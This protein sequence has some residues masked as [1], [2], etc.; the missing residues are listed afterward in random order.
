VETHVGSKPGRCGEE[1]LL[2]LAMKGG[3]LIIFNTSP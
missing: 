2:S 1:A 3:Y